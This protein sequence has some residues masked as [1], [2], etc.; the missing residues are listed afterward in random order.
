MT[1]Q[2]SID[3]EQLVASHRGGRERNANFLAIVHQL[4]QVEQ[5]LGHVPKRRLRERKFV[6][7]QNKVGK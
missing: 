6:R 2:R 3:P 4:A 5:L 7:T 1:H